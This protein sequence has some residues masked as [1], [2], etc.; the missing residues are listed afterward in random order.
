M[1]VLTTILFLLTLTSYGQDR[2]PIKLGLGIIEID[3]TL[4][5]SKIVTV[6]KDKNLKTKIED[7]K[8][9]GD[10]KRVWPY[11]DKPDYGLCYFICIAKTKGYYKILF[12]DK[13]EG[14]LKNDSDKYF[15]SWESI[16]TTTTV[17]RVDIKSNP[18]RTKPNDRSAVIDLGYEATV[19][20]LEAFEV[21][22]IN[23]E[24]WIKVY[25]SKS[26]KDTIDRGTSDR[27]EGW[28][29]WKSGEKL[30]VH[31]ILLC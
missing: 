19:D 17:Q 18:L 14:F 23:G 1:R 16:L 28:I 4:D 24:N 30:L 15:K 9:Y 7:F 8:L 5:E 13:E 20:R 22:E 3:N 21:V 27:G 2:N 26:G 11:F 6:Y 29:K 25:F 10:H 31:L 12:N